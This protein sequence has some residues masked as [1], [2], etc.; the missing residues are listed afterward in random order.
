MDPQNRILL[1]QSALA[2]T[3][4]APATGPLADTRTGVYI[5]CMYQVRRLGVL[6]SGL[7]GF[8]RELHA[9]DGNVLCA[10]TLVSSC[11]PQ[12][13]QQL[14]YNLG[15]KITAIVATGNGL[16]YSTGRLSYTFGLQVGNLA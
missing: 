4:A 5:G 3:D 11:A 8:A 2:L 12:E 9:P 7:P 14:H 1:E 10:R 6:E 15:H 13:Y 16:A